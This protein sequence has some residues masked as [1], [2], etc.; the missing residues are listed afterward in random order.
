MH[1]VE[2]HTTRKRGLE[3]HEKTTPWIESR[4]TATRMTPLQTVKCEVIDRSI[5]RIAFLD[6][7]RL[8]SIVTSRCL[9]L[10]IPAD[11]I[12]VVRRRRI[13]QM[14]CHGVARLHHGGVSSGARQARQHGGLQKLD[15]VLDTVM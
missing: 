6:Q 9:N 14:K 10:V 12:F 4:P 8:L 7:P 11:I 1:E 13:L 5:A 2:Q 3:Y 15:T